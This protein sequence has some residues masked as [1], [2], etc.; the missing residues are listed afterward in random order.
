MRRSFDDPT[1]GGSLRPRGPI[2]LELTTRHEASLT[3]VAVSGELDAL[4]APKLSIA[5]DDVIR[6]HHGDVVLD[7][8]DA[9]FIDSLGLHTL[10]GVQRRLSRQSRSLTVFCG[11]GAVRRA[12]EL[13]RLDE[14]FRLVSTFAEY[15]LRRSA[16]SG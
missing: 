9:D 1:L 15:E 8:T 5:L 14:A 2:H 6:R 10:L 16:R 12:I 7:L 3:V 13:A 11:E 4:T